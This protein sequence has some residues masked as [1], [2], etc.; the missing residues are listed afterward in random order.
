VRVLV[1]DTSVLVDMERGGILDV[2]FTLPFEF[3]VPDLLYKRELADHGGEG[4]IGLG[5]RVEGLA[6]EEVIAAQ[7]VRAAN[8]KM[9]L[10]DAFA[11]ALASGRGWALLAGD[12]ILRA[13]ADKQQIPV[14]GVLWVFDRVH[15]GR[16]MAGVALADCSDRLAAHPRCRLPKAEIAKRLEHYRKS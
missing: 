14:H 8:P 9:S 4:L 3:A 11:F 1:S 16:M 5:L 13:L 10:P 7:S 2:C 6:P 12:G 15:D